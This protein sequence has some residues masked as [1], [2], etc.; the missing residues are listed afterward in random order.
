MPLVLAHRGSFGIYPEHTTAGYHISY[1]EGAHFVDV[2]L[3]PTKD[4]VLVA[5]HEPCFTGLFVG[6]NEHKHIYSD[7]K[8]V[9]FTNPLHGE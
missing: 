5:H 6:M 9:N 4:G 7:D 8:R 3:Q 1:Y 2:D